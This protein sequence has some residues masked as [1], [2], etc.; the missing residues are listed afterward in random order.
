MTIFFIKQLSLSRD[1]EEELKAKGKEDWAA[2]VAKDKGISTPTKE[3]EDGSIEM[4][5]KKEEV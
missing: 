4:E 2:K 3:S 1:N 5:R